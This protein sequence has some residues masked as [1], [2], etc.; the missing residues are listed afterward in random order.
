MAANTPVLPEPAESV[1]ITILRRLLVE[2]HITPDEFFVLLEEENPGRILVKISD[3]TL[4][5]SRLI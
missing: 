1:K 2:E 5:F 3:K 4:S